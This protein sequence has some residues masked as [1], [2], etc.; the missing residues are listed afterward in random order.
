[1]KIRALIDVNMTDA[2]PCL[3]TGH[4]GI[5]HA[6]ANQPRSAAGNEKV[7][8]TARA[9]ER[10]CP[11]PT[12]ILRHGDERFGKS[13]RRQGAA[14]RFYDFKGRGKGFLSPAQHA[15]VAAF[16]TER[17]RVRSDVRTAFID[18]GH[19]PHGDRD[20]FD[21]QTVRAKDSFQHS[22][23]GIGEFC[24][25]SDSLRHLGYPF[26]RQ[27]QSVGHGRRKAGSGNVRLICRK[28]AGGI[29]NQRIRHGGQC[30]VLSLG[31]ERR[32][33]RFCRFRFPQGLLHRFHISFRL[34]ENFVPQGRPS[35]IS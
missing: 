3:N 29:G 17:R 2:R 11:F 7:Y 22:P 10:A 12:R 25:R 18:N 19:H 15:G 5:F 13:R 6:G 33:N 24:Y 28:Y 32:R 1:M 21:F 14:E 9:H 26:L 4:R 27:C 31:G 35:T 16:Q 20:L 30:L 34:P 23:H 8:K